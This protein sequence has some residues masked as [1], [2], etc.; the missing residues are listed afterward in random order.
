MKTLV[1]TH[2][3]I[4]G[5]F[6]WLPMNKNICDLL[7]SNVKH[8]LAYLQAEFKSERR[9][10][11]SASGWQTSH[12]RLHTQSRLKMLEGFIFYKSSINGKVNVALN[13][14]K[15]PNCNTALSLWAYCIIF[16]HQQV[17]IKFEFVG[18][19]AVSF[20]M[21]PHSI[22]F[23]FNTNATPL[24][25]APLIYKKAPR[26]PYNNF[27]ILLLRSRHSYENIPF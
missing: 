4:L 18:S 11:F 19:F 5:S 21:Q 12:T 24:R 13:K 15:L 16:L 2:T 26:S 3:F 14:T 6:S 27:I 7:Y 20:T 8:P 25:G 22:T 9:S 17:T 1:K 10:D 23:C